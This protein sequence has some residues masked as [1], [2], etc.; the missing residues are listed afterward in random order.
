MAKN[1][2]YKILYTYAEYN[3]AGT[4]VFESGRSPV[5]TI[6]IT[7]TTSIEV[8]YSSDARI[9]RVRIY[10]T[11]AS[12]NVFYLEKTITNVVGT[13][14]T[15]TTLSMADATLASQATYYNTNKGYET[16]RLYSAGV[17]PPQQYCVQASGRLWAAGRM[18][19]GG[20]NEHAT[21]VWSELAPNYE[22]FPPANA[23]T[24]FA[25]GITG[26]YEWNELVYVLTWNSRW[27]VTPADYNAGFQIDKLEGEIGCAGGHSIDKIGSAVIWLHHTGFYVVVGDQDPVKISGPIEDTI[28][29]L[30]KNRMKFAMGRNYRPDHEYR[31]WVTDGDNQT[32]DMCLTYD[33]SRGL[34]RGKWTVRGGYG[35]TAM[36]AAT[37]VMPDGSF[38]MFVGDHMGCVWQEDIGTS[39]GATDGGTYQGPLG[40]GTTSTTTTSTTTSTTTTT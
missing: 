21:L 26:L 19:R 34:T 35:R 10:S 3:D 40:K 9:N 37:G 12:G 32:N 15:W 17:L 33:Y 22:D 25:E 38:Q 23:S 2:S 5:R 18:H 27:R 39:D 30:D 16:K 4:M 11:L 8:K 14:S 7:G 29:G 13:G 20:T 1:G 24:R 31:C 6:T 28:D 36:Y